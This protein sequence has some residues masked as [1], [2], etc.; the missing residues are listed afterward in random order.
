MNRAAVV[1]GELTGV[2]RARQTRFLNELGVDDIQ[3]DSTYTAHAE[4]VREALRE[5]SEAQI[6]DNCARVRKHMIE[7]HGAVPDEHGRCQ[8]RPLCQRRHGVDARGCAGVRATRVAIASRQLA[9]C[10][11]PRA[12]CRP[13]FRSR[14]RARG[15]VGD[16]AGAL[17]WQAAKPVCKQQ[18][19]RHIVDNIRVV[20][21]ETSIFWTTVIVGY[22]FVCTHARISPNAELRSPTDL[23]TSIVGPYLEPNHSVSP[24]TPSVC[25]ARPCVGR[26][27][28]CCRASPC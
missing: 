9:E 27:C 23:I 26:S 10:R 18:V 20:V 14:S 6:L 24:R 22:F 25:G 28:G 13:A 1:T 7:V 2:R 4:H 16:E 5:L 21:C 12:D 15:S 19:S 8:N 11:V 3:K 17:F